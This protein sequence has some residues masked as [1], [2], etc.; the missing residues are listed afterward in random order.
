MPPTIEQNVLMGGRADFAS[1]C[2]TADL[3]T[4]IEVGTDRGVFA[5]EFLDRWRGE[6]L[7]CVDPYTPYPEM[8]WDRTGDMALA[9]AH[10][11]PHARRVRFIVA[12]SDQAAAYFRKG[13]PLPTSVG[14]IYI[15]GSHDYASVWNDLNLWWPLVKKGGILA[16]DDY[17]IRDV[18]RAVWEFANEHHLD[19]S[20]ISD[21]NRAMNWMMW[22]P[23][24]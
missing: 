19:I 14:F 17:G 22:K 10:L 8:P 18:Q 7:Y 6:M 23:E 11:A 16:G 12:P 21:Y 9:I 13:E 24:K 4:A 2:D 3:K 5:R 1:L 20:L 15:D